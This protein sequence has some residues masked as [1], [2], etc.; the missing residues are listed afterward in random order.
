MEIEIIR[1]EEYSL[2]FRVDHYKNIYNEISEDIEYSV[3]HE[4]NLDNGILYYFK[5]ES[6]TSSVTVARVSYLPSERNYSESS[7]DTGG[8]QK[9][10]GC[11]FY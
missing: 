1:D 7:L 2:Q 11:M 5:S 8:I 10:T 9:K 4:Y 6:S 3:T